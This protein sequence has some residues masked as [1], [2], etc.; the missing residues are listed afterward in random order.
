MGIPK[1]GRQGLSITHITHSGL[2]WVRRKP[3][4]GLEITLITLITHTKNK[5]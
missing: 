3:N 2:G 1:T 5:G 4:L